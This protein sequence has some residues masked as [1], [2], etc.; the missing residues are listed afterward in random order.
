[1]K[2]FFK[3]LKSSI[4]VVVIAIVIIIPIR[5]FIT[6][7]LMMEPTCCGLNTNDLVIVRKLFNE[8]DLKRGTIILAEDN[9]N[10][11]LSEIVAL[12]NKYLFSDHFTGKFGYLKKDNPA[13]S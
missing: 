3:F 12:P 6:P 9:G 5:A 4:L 2:S 8:S 7:F 1:L 13:L 11:F 10:S